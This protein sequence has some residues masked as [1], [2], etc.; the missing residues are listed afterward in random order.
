M[1]LPSLSFASQL[2]TVSREDEVAKNEQVGVQIKDVV[3][4]MPTAMVALPA[5][6]GS[7]SL[8]AQRAMATAAHAD[9]HH[10]A[11]YWVAHP[12]H[13]LPPSPWPVLGGFGA[14]VTMLGE[15]SPDRDHLAESRTI[16]LMRAGWT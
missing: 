13:V 12:F 9:D 3:P 14:G 4:K 7:Q 2:H 8:V 15:F 11:P 6:R 5:R 1:R 16:N 10:S